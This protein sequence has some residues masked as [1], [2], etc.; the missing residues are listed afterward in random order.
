MVLI[1][2]LTSEECINFFTPLK[3]R[4]KKGMI[5]IIAIYF[6]SRYNYWNII[7]YMMEITDLKI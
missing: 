7:F 4:M 3:K 5:L 1:L 6:T 2:A